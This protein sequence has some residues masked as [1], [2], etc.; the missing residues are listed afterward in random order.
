MKARKRTKLKLRHFPKGLLESLNGVLEEAGINE[1]WY[2]GGATHYKI[3]FRDK[4]I[5]RKIP[6]SFS[7]SDHRSMKNSVAHL[8][9]L[10]EGR[11]A[12]DQKAGYGIR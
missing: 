5:L 12:D 6:V 4:G 8:R 2:E 11:I 10:T 9:R 1:I 3:C 7:P